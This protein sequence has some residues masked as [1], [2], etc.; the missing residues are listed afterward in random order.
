MKRRQRLTTCSIRPGRQTTSVAR[1]NSATS[2]SLEALEPSCL[3][4]VF[5]VSVRHGCSVQGSG[6]AVW[7]KP[8]FDFEFVGGEGEAGEEGDGGEGAELRGGLL[9]GSKGKCREALPY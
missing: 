6:L 9:V 1:V 7:T 8:D 3:Y 4:E 2:S 5:S